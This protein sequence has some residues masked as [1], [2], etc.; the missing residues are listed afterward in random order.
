MTSHAR[1][2]SSRLIYF[3]ARIRR[4]VFLRWFSHSWRKTHSPSLSNQV[5]LIKWCCTFSF[6]PVILLSH[7]TLQQRVLQQSKNI[8]INIMEQHFSI[9]NVFLLCISYLQI[10]NL[11]KKNRHKQIFLNSRQ[12][13]E[14]FYLSNLCFCSG[15]VS[16]ETNQ[17]GSILSE[18]RYNIVRMLKN[19]NEV[20]SKIAC[21]TIN[22]RQIDTSKSSIPQ[23]QLFL[24]KWPS[25]I[26]FTFVFFFRCKAT[27]LHCLNKTWQKGYQIICRKRHLLGNPYFR[28]VV[29]CNSF[30][31]IIFFP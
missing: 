18:T 19:T 5:C 23:A 11:K 12:E 17:N 7:F 31:S 15:I 10:V 29:S 30:K 21:T 8:K 1:Q 27:K 6:Q 20:L 28:M 24:Q 14:C 9:E 26:S 25:I 16:G 13:C 22:G 2:S 4:V 3:I